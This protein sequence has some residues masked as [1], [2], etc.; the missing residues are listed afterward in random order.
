MHAPAGVIERR[1]AMAQALRVLEPD[2]QLTALA[3]KERGGARIAKELVGF[4]CRVEQT[5]RRHHCICA[6]R[7]P[8]RPIGLGEAIAAG[9]P[10]VPPALGLWSQPGVFSW[11]RPD[12]GSLALIRHLPALS[13]AGADF[14]CGVGL[15]ARAVLEEPA[16]TGLLLIDV[17][18]RALECARLNVTDA[19]ARYVWGDVRHD[20]VDCRNLDFV[21][22]NPPFHDGGVEDRTLGESFIRRAAAVLRPG[23]VCWLVANRH[24]PYEQPLRSSFT[25]IQLVEQSDGFKIYEAHQ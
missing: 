18:R 11:D 6:T 22:M 19:R 5:S 7:R 25:A 17:D 2:G 24:L 16:V 20:A 3:S 12:T 1:Y 23:G 14:G 15:L 8:E 13:G 4:A 21:V 10:Q 9:G